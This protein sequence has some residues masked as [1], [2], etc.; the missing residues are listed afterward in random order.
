MVRDKSN[1]STELRPVAGALHPLAPARLAV[2][3]IVLAATVAVQPM[4]AAQP[5][6]AAAAEL[7]ASGKLDAALTLLDG[8]VAEHPGDERLFPL[9]LGV[10]TAAPER[11]TVD[12]VLRRYREALPVHQVGVLRAVP[13]DFA[14]LRGGVEQALE[15]LRL[16]RLPDAGQRRAVLLLELGQLVPEA[17]PGGVPIAL[18]AG[19]ARSSEMLDDASLEASLRTVFSTPGHGDGGAGGAVAGYGLVALLAGRGRH[20]DANSVLA[21]LRR[22]YPRSPEYALAAAEL[23]SG[24]T[25]PSVVSLPSPTM[26]LRSAAL[27]CRSP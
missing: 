3:L 14:E 9:V 19:L 22:R 4:H 10:V 6:G 7:A 25:P 15:E 13:A 24:T 26:L 18:H 23:R 1:A 16:S 8:W 20:A 5:P 17:A 11:T 2:G 27:A 12:A 21:E